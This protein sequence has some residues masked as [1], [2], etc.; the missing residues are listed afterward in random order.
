MSPAVCV[1]RLNTLPVC[2]AW[3]VLARTAEPRRKEGLTEEMRVKKGSRKV[4]VIIHLWNKGQETVK[5]F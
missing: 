5:R 4:D 1:N 2:E 3:N